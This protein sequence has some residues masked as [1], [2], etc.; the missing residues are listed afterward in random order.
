M[1]SFNALILLTFVSSFCQSAEWATC[2]L[3]PY[4]YSDAIQNLEVSFHGSNQLSIHFDKAGAYW[5]VSLN[6]L[7]KSGTNSIL[8]VNDS[9][10]RDINLHELVYENFKR[11]LEQDLFQVIQRVEKFN[12]PLNP[13]IKGYSLNTILDPSSFKNPDKRNFSIAIQEYEEDIIFTKAV[14][15]ESSNDPS[16]TD[17]KEVVY[18]FRKSCLI[19]NV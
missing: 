4:F 12:L 18:Q 1:K 14:I 11:I 10:D 8:R 16:L 13:L 3:T 19:P 15:S 17:I 6:K 5:G 9:F 7:E 2:K